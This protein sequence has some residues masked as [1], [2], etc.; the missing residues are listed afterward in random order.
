MRNASFLALCSLCVAGCEPPEGTP[1]DDPGSPIS[2]AVDQF[3]LVVFAD[4]IMPVLT[5]DVD[6]NNPG[7]GYSGCTREPCH[8]SNRGPGALFLD[9]SDTDANNL[10]RFA[11]FVNLD[12][13]PAS[14]V[15]V[16]PLGEAG[17]RVYPHPGA[18]LFSGVEDLNYQRLLSYLMDSAAAATLADPPRPE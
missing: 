10:S 8:G 18:D 7:A 17:C 5:G 16:C 3:D 4:E 6:L 14:Q 11:C 9:V 12:D 13:P 15:L 1:P 2:C